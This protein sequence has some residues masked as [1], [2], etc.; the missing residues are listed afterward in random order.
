MLSVRE[1]YKPTTV[2]KAVGPKL[3]PFFKTVVIFF[4]LF[5]EDSR[6]E[7]VFYCIVKC[8]PVISLMI[9]VLLHGMS[10]SE[11]YAYS[12]KILIGLIF[13]CL[14]DAFLVWKNCGYFTHG[15]AMFALAQIMYV[16]AFGLFKPLALRTGTI[17]ATFGVAMYLFL[18]PGLSGAMTYLAAVYVGLIATMAWRA[19]ARV[20]FLNDQWTWTGLC[21]SGGAV[22]FLIS[23]SVI[24][25]NKFRF[26]VPYS[27]QIIMLT[28]YF[29][30]LGIS[31]S[32][33][34]S[35]VDALIVK[36]GQKVRPH[37]D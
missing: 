17:C 28:Y 24:A 33:V 36:T 12:R 4:I 5:E 21:S 16:W 31:V 22:L 37:G 8:L 20:K 26:D 29:A 30:Q 2:L 1:R 13:S 19:I 18:L 14:G 11:I 34:D 3:V 23:D 7:S 25:I 6:L 35:H 10:L 15:L 27:H 32:V 9:F